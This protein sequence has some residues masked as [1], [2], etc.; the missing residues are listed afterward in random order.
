MCTILLA[1]RCFGDA[2]VVFAANRD[3][4]RSRPSAPPGILADDPLVA[5]GR[6]LLAGGT[7][8]AV[9]ETGRI[10]AVTNR[11]AAARDPSRRSRGEIP[12]HLL[13]APADTIGA[14]M[15]ALSPDAYNPF[16]ALHVSPDRAVAAHCRGEGIVEVV[17]LEPGPHVITVH[18][19]D[20]RSWP[21]VAF[22]YGRLEAAVTVSST[23]AEL[24]PAMEELLRDHGQGGG[25]R[26][27]GLDPQAARGE[28][29]PL[30]GR[31]ELE[32]A[33]VH[34]D[35]YG[36]VSSSSVVVHAGGKITHRHAP[37]PPCVTEHADVSALLSRPRTGSPR[38]R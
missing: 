38:S 22:L 17:E 14:R 15:G 1:W 19:T 8:L 33:C 24:L 29:P 27:R 21:K 25:P 12:L 28:S 11:F 18:D 32:H 5:G 16:N 4:L 35:G 3:E 34:A 37:G 23:A 2:P 13:D 36:T 7:W 30:D 26:S 20:D 31:S 10:A 6:D 9:S